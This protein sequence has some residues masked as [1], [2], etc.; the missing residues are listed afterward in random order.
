MINYPIYLTNMNRLTTTK[1]MV[2]DLFNLNGNARITIIDNAST[3]PPLLEWYDTIKSDVNII[4]QSTNL[5]CWTFF[6][7][8]HANSCKEEYYVYSDADLE[9]NPK[10]PYN[11]QEVLMDYHKRW[12]RKASLVLRLDDVSPGPI[13]DKILNH[14][15]VCWDPTDEENVWKGITDM[16]FSFDS[17]SAGYRYESVRI[18]D[19]FAC[20]H[21]PWYLDFNNLPGE[22]IYYLQHLDNLYPD[23][24]WSNLHKQILMDSKSN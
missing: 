8:G 2:E 10:M 13:K 14:Q 11:W 23:A 19:A 9:L 5:G 15:S 17:K 22:E 3:Y 4:K 12:N 1:K 6:Y 24:L 18:G 7:S 21:M 16:T 20:R